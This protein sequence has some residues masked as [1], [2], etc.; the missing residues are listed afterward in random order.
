MVATSRNYLVFLLPFLLFPFFFSVLGFFFFYST[1]RCP[2]ALTP[3]VS[4]TQVRKP[5]YVSHP[6]SERHGGHDKVQ[7]AGP[8][9]SAV[10]LFIVLPLHLSNRDGLRRIVVIQ[11]LRKQSKVKVLQNFKKWH[12]HP[13]SIEHMMLQRKD[14]EMRT[15]RCLYPFSILFINSKKQQK[16][17][18]NNVQEISPFC[19]F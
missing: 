9:P 3:S 18:C 5:P 7:L 6:H 19:W 2:P 11:R 10:F 17:S 1:R 15:G 14:A 13:S 8:L 12:P 16:H 4:V